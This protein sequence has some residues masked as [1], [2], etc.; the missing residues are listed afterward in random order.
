MRMNAAKSHYR[1]KE[2]PSN[3]HPIVALLLTVP[4][5]EYLS[6]IEFLKEIRNTIKTLFSIGRQHS[7]THYEESAPG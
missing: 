7:G 6:Y 5:T 2:Y 3:R 4:Q 1:C